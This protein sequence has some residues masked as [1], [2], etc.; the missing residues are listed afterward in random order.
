MRVA[1]TSITAIR[2]NG[3]RSNDARQS[4][5]P[6]HL[7]PLSYQPMAGNPFVTAEDPTPVL[8]VV[9]TGRGGMPHFGEYL[10]TEELA[11][12]ISYVRNGWDNNASAVSTEQVEEADQ[13]FSSPAEVVGH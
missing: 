8:Q 12:V 3:V 10:T 1:F 5:D 9:L 4:S 13:Q 6:V 2:R 7:F 11:A